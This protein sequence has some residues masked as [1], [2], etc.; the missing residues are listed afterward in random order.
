M[1]WNE[2]DH[3]TQ[4]EQGICEVSS[5]GHGGLRITKKYADEHL[6][7]HAIRHSTWS[8]R[9]HHYY[10][11]DLD[12]YIAMYEL[13]HLWNEWFQYSSDMKHASQEERRAHIKSRLRAYPS[14]NTSRYLVAVEKS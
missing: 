4:L 12:C 7:D 10:E 3:S 1:W 14:G 11:E 13:P 2:I 5:P 6:S 8:N 9:T